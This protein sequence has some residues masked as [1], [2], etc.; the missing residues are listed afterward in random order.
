MACE[1]PANMAASTG[2]EKSKERPTKI[3]H[4]SREVRG[5]TLISGL[6]TVSKP[7]KR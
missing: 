5:G 1:N 6:P 2:M 7:G 4:F 3:C